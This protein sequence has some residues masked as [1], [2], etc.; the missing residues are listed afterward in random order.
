LA[1]IWSAV[2]WRSEQGRGRL[3]GSRQTTS[4]FCIVH[5]VMT[6]SG[7]TNTIVVHVKKDRV[8]RRLSSCVRTSSVTLK[9]A[10]SSIRSA[11][12]SAGAILLKRCAMR[13]EAA[14]AAL[15]SPA[16]SSSRG[17]SLAT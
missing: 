12:R 13:L 10:S 9:Q 5:H 15:P 1:V 7:N 2:T 4:A 6:F 17:Q 11:A 8:T 3:E 14:P 16:S